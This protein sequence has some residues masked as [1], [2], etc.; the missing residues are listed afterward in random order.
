[1]DTVLYKKFLLEYILFNS[2]MFDVEK[3]QDYPYLTNIVE[4]INKIHS[5]GKI[6]KASKLI[7]DLE[8]Y[9]KDPDLT[10]PI[11][12]ILSIIAENNVELIKERL[13]EEIEQYIHSDNVKLKINSIIILG[14]FIIRNF[15]YIEKYFPDFTNL[16]ANN[17]EDIRDNAHYFLQEFIKVAPNLIES[18]GNVILD[19]LSFEKSEEN[20][21]SLLNFLDYIE[22]DSIE[23]EQLYKFR[24]ISK[25]LILTYSTGK[26]SE[27]FSILISLLKKFFPALKDINFQ[28]QKID[29][30]INIL[31]NLFLMKK[32]DLV[33]KESFQLKDLISKIKESSFKDKEI[34]FFIKNKKNNITSFYELE[35]EKLDKVFKKKKRISK[36]N[37]LETFSEIIESENDLKKI[38]NTL[39]KLEYVN[40]YFSKL[41]Y[42]YPYDYLKSEIVA[43]V[44]KKGI[45]N[46][47]SKYDFLPPEFVQKII[48]EM[49]QE[50]LLNKNGKIYYSLKKLQNNITAAATKDNVI[51]LKTYREKLKDEHF[52]RLIK[53]LPESYLTNFRKGTYWLTN[54]GKIKIENE[55]E[56]SKIVGFFDLNKISTKLKIHKILLMD[57]LEYSIDPRSG[58]W[59]N[60]KEIFYFSK[61]IKEKINQ[62]NLI[63]DE[64]ERENHI[65]NLANE[66]NIEKNHIITNINENYILIG[67]EIKQ[68]D[69]IKISVYIEKTGMEYENFIEFM[70]E[71][72]IF[73]FRKGDLLILNPKKIEEE[74]NNIKLNLIENSKSSNYISLGN[75]DVT[76]NLIENLIYDLK[77]DGKVKGIFYNKEDELVFYTERGIRNLMLENNMLFSFEDLFFGKELAPDEVELLKEIF[78]DLIRK[79]KLRG[80]FDEETLTFSSDDVIFANDYN[81][82]LHEFAKNVNNYIKKFEFE[83]K[84]I[85]KILTKKKETIY[86][87]EIRIIQD[88]IDKINKKYIFW[89]DGLESFV[90]KVNNKLLKDQ[91]YSVKRYKSLTLERKDEIKS[92]EEDPEVYDLLEAFKGWVRL[93]NEIELKYPNVIFY[94]K[95][96]INNSED[97]ESEKNLNELL[98]NLNLI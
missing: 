69:Q 44:Q 52:I 45:I 76:S 96:L 39:I 47:K 89:R 60:N 68:Q 48:L 87:Q 9:L 15:E 88:S 20:I 93:F 21:I 30:L 97:T 8:D 32:Y 2:I 74:K 40:G 85:R 19:A 10:V 71:L 43:D 51:N 22:V 83:F 55:I 65:E 7:D 67:E 62:I 54:I 12:Y 42:F 6:E 84:K 94:Q 98:I 13:I 41:G 28:Y 29:K 1:M 33:K 25:S 92:F 5:K 64:S 35:K 46:I 23:F 81:T 86:P 11:T 27:I 82:N 80:T 38:I 57:V 17:I 95:R 14:F 61:Y 77:V 18:Y 78:S 72:D 56:N 70:N 16:L 49:K 63:L 53:N 4:K 50:F 36:H 26:S 58:Q 59:D 79:K 31:D 66:L 34:Y 3:F 91:G 75:F 90:K 37:L 24:K 73:F